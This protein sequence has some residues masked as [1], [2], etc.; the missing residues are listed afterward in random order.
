LIE[1]FV[2]EGQSWSRARRG[3]EMTLALQ[4]RA[5]GMMSG[6]LGGAFV[7]RDKK[8]DP[9][10]RAPIEVVPA[11]AQR[12]ALRFLLETTFRDDAY[13]LTPDLLRRMTVDKWLDDMSFA[14]EDPTWPVHDRIMGIQ[15]AVLTRLMNPGTLGRVYDNEFL[16][17]SKE[18]MVTLPE[19]LNTLEDEIW[20]ECEKEQG[21]YTER[22]PM[23]SSLRRNLQ[24][25]FVE[26]LIDLSM[27]SSWS[28]VSHRPLANLALM[29]LRRLSDRIG[30]C[31]DDKKDSLDAY[32]RAHLSEAK[33]RIEKALDAGYV[34]NSGGLGNGGQII[35]VVGQTNAP[36]LV[37]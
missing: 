28:Q 12:D 1:K 34:L 19:I 8:G 13:G 27:P 30:K 6:W 11:K 18:D 37:R 17:P 2:R 24:R 3:Y 36:V 35:I 5:V 32:S 21:H 7:N 22:E 26:R 16:T 20:S 10:N 23:I 29:H 31:F 33:L 9:G 4:T 14:F 25:E 15:A